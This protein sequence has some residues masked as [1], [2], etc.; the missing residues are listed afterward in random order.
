[1]KNWLFIAKNHKKWTNNPFLQQLMDNSSTII[2]HKSS[3]FAT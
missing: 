1:M 3:N 2:S